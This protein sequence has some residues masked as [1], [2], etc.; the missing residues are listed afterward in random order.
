MPQV[1]LLFDGDGRW[2]RAEVLGWDPARGRAL[3]LYDDG[4]D[5]WVELEAEEL[6][7]HRPLGAAHSGVAPGLPRGA[8][9]R[10]GRCWQRER[11]SCTDGDLRV[12]ACFVLT[13]S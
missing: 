2:Y 3:L 8:P 1:S 6:S 7:W 10:R 5:E 4:E 11:Q 12:H 9:W 13:H